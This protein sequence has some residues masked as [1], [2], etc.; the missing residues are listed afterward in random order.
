GIKNI[1]AGNC[2]S[3]KAINPGAEASGNSV[4]PAT[5]AGSPGSSAILMTPFPNQVTSFILQFCWHRT[6]TD[7][8]A[9]SLKH[10]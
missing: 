3:G 7:S 9:V 4:K 2:R 10:T 5:T 6:G 1:K 8:G